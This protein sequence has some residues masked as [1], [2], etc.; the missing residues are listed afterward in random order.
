MTDERTLNPYDSPRG[1]EESRSWWSRLCEFFTP[2]PPLS[3]VEQFLSGKR[4]IF[5]GVV[6]Q[7]SLDDSSLLFA[8]L[9]LG[10]MEPRRVRNNIVEAQRV[11]HLLLEKY[12]E[13]VSPLYGRNLVV[14][15]I[16]EYGGN[17]QNLH[18]EF[19]PT[20]TWHAWREE[21]DA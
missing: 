10:A 16:S 4:A 8:F 21:E 1:M 9:P 3:L 20:E 12:P 2:R 17:A 13:L 18:R 19:V 6:F 7:M 15:L 14:F 5:H 11:T